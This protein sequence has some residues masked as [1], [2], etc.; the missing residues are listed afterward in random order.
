MIGH[1]SFL[2]CGITVGVVFLSA[3][4]KSAPKPFTVAEVTIPEMR[5]AMESKRITSRELV[6]MYLVS[7]GLHEDRLETLLLPGLSG[8]AVAAK[9]GYPTVV[10][11]LGMV[12]NAPTPAFP[13]GFEAKPAPFGVSF[14]GMACSEARLLHRAFAFEQAAKRRIPP[15]A[16][17]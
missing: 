1:I 3:Q 10:V 13:A 9:L 16:F 6:A 5:T 7:I 11:P 17:P 14:T 12:P 15:P 4:E 8:A 2:L